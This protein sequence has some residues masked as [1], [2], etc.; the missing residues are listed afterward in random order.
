MKL[1]F[2]GLSSIQ[3]L[4][5]FLLL[6][7]MAAFADLYVF[8]SKS[9]QVE[10]YDEVTG[11]ISDMRAS[12]TKLEYLL[13]MFVVAR[14]FEST[15]IELIKGDV[16]ELDDNVSGLLADSRFLKLF[17]ANAPLSEG[18]DSVAEDWQNIKVEISRLNDAL[19]Q[20]EIMLIHNAVDIH[21]VLV[22]EKIDRLLSLISDSRQGVFN[23][24]RSFE[25]KS[26]AGFVLLSFLA[27][28]AYYKKFAAP[29]RKAGAVARRVEGGNIESRFREDARSLVGRFGGELNRMLE[30][31]A[32]EREEFKALN[33]V[34]GERLA[35]EGLKTRSFSEL[36]SLASTSLSPALVLKKAVTE[37]V[38]GAGADAGAAFIEEGGVLKL[39][40]LSGFGSEAAKGLHQVIAY[41]PAEG[42]R[43]CATT[44]MFS[45][46]AD[47]PDSSLGEFLKSCGFESMA[48]VPIL[49]NG[50]PLGFLFVLYR[51]RVESISHVSPFL[52]A[53]C[54]GAAVSIGHAG[55]Y[56]DERN[57]R[58]FIEQLVNQVPFGLA[59]FDK[60]GSCRVINA[61]LKKILGAER[62]ELVGEYS[63]L[64]DK[65]L[66]AGGILPSVK[67]AYDGYATE[68][69]INYD[70]ALMAQFSCSGPRKKLRI[71]CFPLYDA[72]GDISN[73][74]L[75]YEDLCN[76]PEAG[77]YPGDAL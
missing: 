41:P 8:S 28:I 2:A 58:R 69:T 6:V 59:V 52:E 60:S 20:D 65:V 23:E 14:R 19:N 13:D 75:L 39:K 51:K 35:A 10:L 70:P 46:I 22:A 17:E 11:R 55:L 3:K 48:R 37:A 68:F 67:K 40:A 77:A 56:Q 73:I 47:Y 25:V 45:S 15:T 29:L 32:R 36:M 71:K 44:A 49:Y 66:K 74:V 24:I 53:L 57:S 21:T 54:H 4:L 63:I 62:A 9:G 50:R 26:V 42:E 64:G 18:F 43:H 76:L 38:S 12:I 30:T 1:S 5:I 61:T 7:F 33:S 72:G 27:A 16:D 31:L 34:A